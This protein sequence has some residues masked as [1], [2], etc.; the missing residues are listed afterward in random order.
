MNDWYIQTLEKIYQDQEEHHYIE[1][2]DCQLSE[3]KNESMAPVNEAYL[4]L[5]MMFNDLINAGFSHMRLALQQLKWL[6]ERNNKSSRCIITY[7]DEE[8]FPEDEDWDDWYDPFPMHVYAKVSYGR[9]RISRQ[10]VRMV[11]NKQKRFITS[12]QSQRKV[13][14][15]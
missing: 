2:E 9:N 11:P 3:E 13:Y 7:M 12:I 1:I 8:D 4:Q 15:M 6:W 5:R 14:E 10:S